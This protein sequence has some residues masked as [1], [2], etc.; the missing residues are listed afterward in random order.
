MIPAEWTQRIHTHCALVGIGNPLCG[1]DGFGPF[2]ISI[3]QH[4]TCLHLFDGGLAPENLTGPLRRLAPKQAIL[5]DTI[6]ASTPPGSLCW[7]EP[8]LLQTATCSTHG[9]SIDLLAT[10]LSQHL[11]IHVH[12]IGLVPQQ[13]ALGTPLSQTAI[14][15]ARELAQFI[16]THW[17]PNKKEY[18]HAR[19][20]S[21]L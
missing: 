5:L 6:P 2:V 8:Q 16:E 7:I 1:D 19:E 18:H 15:S 12:L 4:R 9:P 13:T 11:A 21:N 17:P 20:D 3:L 10:Y 14:Q